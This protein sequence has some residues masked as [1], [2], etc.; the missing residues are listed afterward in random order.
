MRSIRKIILEAVIKHAQGNIAKHKANID[1]YLN[2][3]VGIGE[4]S[5]II[6]SIEKELES[7]DKYQSQIDIID[8]YFSSEATIL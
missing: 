6:E 1:I 4:H 3:S 8:N 5:D 7:I 2:H